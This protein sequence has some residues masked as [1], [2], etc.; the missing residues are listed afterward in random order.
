MSISS[1]VNPVGIREEAANCSGNRKCS[2]LLPQLGGCHMT[3][4]CFRFLGSSKK[5]PFLSDFESDK[6]EVKID[7][8]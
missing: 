5:P 2:Y 6:K 4:I 3:A 1:A 7:L 8:C